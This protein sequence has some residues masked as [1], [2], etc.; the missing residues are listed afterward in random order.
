[1]RLGQWNQPVQALATNR[2]D[3]SFADRIRHRTARWRF[4]HLD[5]EPRDRLVEMVG[6][7]TVAIVNQVFV[8]VL[9]SN[10]LTQLLQRPGGTRMGRYITMDQAPAAVFDQH[11]HVQRRDR[12]GYGNE[13]ITSHDS[14][15]MQAQ[16]CRPAH[17]PPRPTRRS[18]RQVLPHGSWRHSKSKFQ[19]ELI[20]NA[21]FTPHR[22]LVRH[23]ADKGLNPLWNR[24]SAASG[25]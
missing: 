22:I 20:G 9:K 4:Q 7:D 1:M 12:G 13:E 23:S 8:P 15:S 19:E 16:E 3:D 11:E 2:A 5:S 25:L 14:L 24:R 6:K 10:C 18:S 21:F 17:I